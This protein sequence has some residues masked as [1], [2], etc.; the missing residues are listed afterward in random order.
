[1]Y[2]SSA[3]NELGLF[4]LFRYPR[5]LWQTAC[6]LFAFGLFR[7]YSGGRFRLP[8]RTTEELFKTLITCSAEPYMAN[9]VF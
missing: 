2:N 6:G 9:F 7:Q 4:Q 8:C 1:M 3:T 5:A